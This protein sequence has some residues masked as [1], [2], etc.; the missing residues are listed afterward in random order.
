MER[1]NLCPAIGP[2]AL[3][4]YMSESNALGMHL[5]GG[6]LRLLIYSG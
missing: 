4:R 3:R 5:G 2:I 1:A 6:N